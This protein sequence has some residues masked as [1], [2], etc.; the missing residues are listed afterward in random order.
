MP[1]KAVWRIDPS[2]TFARQ[3]VSAQPPSHSHTLMHRWN[4]CPGVRHQ[5][6]P[7]RHG[8]NDILRV[9]TIVLNGRWRNRLVRARSWEL[10]LKCN[11]HEQ[12][13]PSHFSDITQNSG[14][15]GADYRLLCSEEF[16]CVHFIPS[17]NSKPLIPV[18]QP[19]PQ[20]DRR[21]ISLGQSAP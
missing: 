17:N 6:A 14:I 9:S 20:R 10:M 16:V 19:L 3:R 8:P 1:R 5:P 2:L 15:S 12:R 18:W 21:V 7:V 11:V 13:V 4:P